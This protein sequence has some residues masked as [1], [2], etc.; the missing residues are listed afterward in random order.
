M[1][2]V[3]GTFSDNVL[4]KYDLKGSW[5]GRKT[6]HIFSSKS[7]TL[8][9]LDYL[10]IANKERSAKVLLK[11]DVVTLLKSEMN[12]DLNLLMNARLMDYSLFIVIAKKK[13][14]DKK[15]LSIGNRVFYSAINEEYV[16]LMG[17]IDYLTKYGKR[18][19]TENIFRSMVNDPKGI[20]CVEPKEYRDRFYNF[21][22]K[23][24]LI[25][26]DEDEEEEEEKEDNLEKI[27]L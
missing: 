20:S 14:I 13:Q 3:F 16:Y 17:I 21:M 9:D 11:E 6:K 19:I 27:S 10:D 8:K 22:F 5:V 25:S 2:N 26:E 15:K 24:V 12:D 4:C 1:K 18:K 23:H 7:K